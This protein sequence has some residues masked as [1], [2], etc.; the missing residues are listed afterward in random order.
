MEINILRIPLDNIKWKIIYQ[1]I[2]I[3]DSFH[4]SICNNLILN[5][6]ERMSWPPPVLVV[7]LQIFMGA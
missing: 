3:L 4:E 7:Q 5:V 6:I 2:T 1:L